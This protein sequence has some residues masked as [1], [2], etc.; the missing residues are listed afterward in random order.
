MLLYGYYFTICFR[1]TQFTLRREGTCVT[2]YLLTGSYAWFCTVRRVR[3]WSHSPL[4]RPFSVRLHILEGLLRVLQ[5]SY[6]SPCF[7]YVC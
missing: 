6:G 4:P 3:W 2:Q 7:P 5:S 1:F